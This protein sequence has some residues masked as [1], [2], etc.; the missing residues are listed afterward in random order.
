MASFTRQCYFTWI[1]YLG[2][3]LHFQN[4][5]DW[6]PGYRMPNWTETAFMKR[7]DVQAFAAF[8]DFV[9]S[10]RER[11][12]RLISALIKNPTAHVTEAHHMPDDVYDFHIARLSNL[13]AFGYNFSK[14]IDTISDY[15]YANKT[16]LREMMLVN[17]SPLLLRCDICLETIVVLDKIYG[18]TNQESLSPLWEHNRIIIAQY[19]KLLNLNIHDCLSVIYEAGL[20][21]NLDNPRNP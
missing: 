18:F 10:L 6:Q 19:G 8:V 20:M 11:Q 4:K 7:N 15:C 3:K 13:R 17:T 5:L 1:D 9:P 2:I 16:T 14:D 21:T 12:D